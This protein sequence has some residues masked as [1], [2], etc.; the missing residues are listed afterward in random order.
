M[1]VGGIYILILAPVGQI[2]IRAWPQGGGAGATGAVQSDS[3]PH[4]KIHTVFSS[5]FTFNLQRG[6]SLKSGCIFTVSLLVQLRLL[7]SYDCKSRS[8]VSYLPLWSGSMGQPCGNTSYHIIL[9]WLQL[10]LQNLAYRAWN[11]F[12]VYWRNRRRIIICKATFPPCLT[13]AIK[14]PLSVASSSASKCSSF[15]SFF[16]FFLWQ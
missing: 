2:V 4:F 8:K 12:D 7:K 14:W 1:V 9:S 15:L 5:Y 6:C 10:T 16:F 3:C 11:M 13:C